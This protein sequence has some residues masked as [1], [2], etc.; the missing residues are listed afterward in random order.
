MFKVNFKDIAFVDP[1][2]EKKIEHRYERYGSDYHRTLINQ[3]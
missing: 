2:S 1:I 3:V